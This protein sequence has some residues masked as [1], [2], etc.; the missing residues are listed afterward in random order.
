MPPKTLI[1]ALLVAVAAALALTTPVAAQWPVTCVD[2]NDIVE[3]HLGNHHNV[4]IYQQVFGEGAEYGCRTDHVEDV[5]GAFAW[6]FDDADRSAAPDLP[7]LAWPTDCVELN[8]IV[9]AHLGNHHNVEIYQRVFGPAAEAG[10]R[11]D[12]RD[13]VRSVFAWA[14]GPGAVPEPVPPSWPPFEGAT[15]GILNGVRYAVSLSDAWIQTAGHDYQRSEPWAILRLRPAGLLER[16][17]RE[18]AESVRDGLEDELRQL[19]PSYSL[20]ELTS[21]RPVRGGEQ[22]A[23]EITYRIQESPRYCVVAVTERIG[24]A[25]TWYGKSQGVRAINWMCEADVPR[26]GGLTKELLDSLRVTGRTDDYYTQSLIANGVLIKA[27]AKV[28]PEALPAAAAVVNWMLESARSD[29]PACMAA[30]AAGLAIIPKDDFVTALPEFASLSGQSDFTGRTYD[31]IELRGLGAVHGQPVTATSE[32]SLLGIGVPRDPHV[33]VH[34]FAHAIQNL[35]FAPADDRKWR[36]FYARS[37]Q[38]NFR[39]GSHQMHDVY[40]FFAVF[41]DAYFGVG[42]WLGDPSTSRELIQR[43]FPK[44]FQALQEIYGSPGPLAHPWA[45]QTP[46]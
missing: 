42:H 12:H 10:C 39:P 36:G 4:G 30:S 34:E 40:E 7:D 6:A 45:S 25:T 29:I 16:S 9:E 46:G 18:Q 11:R 28:R 23:Y 43:D 37:V 17:L 22:D 5:R 41:S 14:F 1:R 3:L 26:H 35:C 19:W 38:A 13:D 31:S 15:T 24:A 44:I 32:E 8:D 2:L 21:F 33:T 27:A 20:F